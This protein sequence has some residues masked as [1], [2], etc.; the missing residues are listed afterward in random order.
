MAGAAALAM[1]LMGPTAR[2]QQANYSLP[3]Q[4]TAQSGSTFYYAVPLGFTWDNLAYVPN[5]GDWNIGDHGFDAGEI[6][7]NPTYCG[8][9]G[10]QCTADAG[11]NKSVA[12]VT[13]NN[14]P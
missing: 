12:F 2:A 5:G 9:K 14:D 8:P 6:V 4:P 11:T 7:G 13:I 3:K 1:L 10:D